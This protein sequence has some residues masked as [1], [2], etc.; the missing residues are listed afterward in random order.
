[1]STHHAKFERDPCKAIPIA[2][3]A[4]HNNA[5]NDV[6]CMPNIPATE[7]KSIILRPILIRLERNLLTVMSI[8]EVSKPLA[9]NLF[10]HLIIHN[11]IT[12]VAI[13]HKT[14]GA[15]LVSIHTAWV[16]Y[17]QS[18]DVFIGKRGKS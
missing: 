17:S 3:H 16:V 10:T 7:M 14:V 2:N 1:M 9:T 15:R 11:Q 6:V 8:L 12:K 18:W 4:A 5:I 13:A